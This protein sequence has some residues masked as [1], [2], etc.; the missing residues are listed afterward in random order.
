[1]LN[2]IIIKALLN[3]A[4]KFHK[5]KL[6]L[7]KKKR[8][9]KVVK[10]KRG[11][12]A[13][14]AQINLLKIMTK[15][16]NK[17]KQIKTAIISPKNSKTMI[18]EVRRHQKATIK[19]RYLQ[20]NRTLLLKNL[21]LKLQLKAYNHSKVKKKNHKRRRM[22]G[23]DLSTNDYHQRGWFNSQYQCYDK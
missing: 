10:M 6:K 3:Q 14:I 8:K 5:I 18:S 11:Q 22:V 23:P 13:N 16:S 12:E 19:S 1:M 4:K 20:L 7:L 15:T 21:Q 17:T 2:Q 9:S